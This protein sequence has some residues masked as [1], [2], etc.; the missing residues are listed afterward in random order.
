MFYFCSISAA[1]EEPGEEATA[2]N[3]EEK[4][5]LWR[6]TCLS[7]HVSPYTGGKCSWIWGHVH[8]TFPKHLSV[9]A[10]GSELCSQFI[11]LRLRDDNDR[12]GSFPWYA[13]AARR[14]T[15]AWATPHISRGERQRQHQQ[16]VLATVIAT[17]WK[18]FV[19]GHKHLGHLCQRNC[20][21]VESNHI[22]LIFFLSSSGCVSINIYI[23]FVSASEGE[24][25]DLGSVGK[26]LIPWINPC[27]SSLCWM[28]SNM[29]VLQPNMFEL[30][31]G[32][33]S[34]GLCPARHA[35]NLQI[36][37]GQAW[38]WPR[39]SSLRRGEEGLFDCLCLSHLRVSQGQSAVSVGHHE[40]LKSITLSTEQ[41]IFFL[42][43][44]VV[45]WI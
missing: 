11:T 41:R 16:R 8:F 29:D 14:E 18:H 30:E 17:P 33:A 15:R 28:A 7:Y 21:L 24:V 36:C 19:T 3:A 42:R 6:L 43:T 4:H 22:F 12:P 25:N 38:M 45:I 31:K 40:S 32:S 34:T 10:V 13:W 2:L 37:C 5:A 27:I 20:V 9:K 44:V 1:R 39:K 23:L 35:I 26:G